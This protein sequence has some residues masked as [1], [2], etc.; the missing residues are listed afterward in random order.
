MLRLIVRSEIVGT[1][2]VVG[3]ENLVEAGLRRGPEGYWDTRECN[4]GRVGPASPPKGGS[5]S[6]WPVTQSWEVREWFSEAISGYVLTKGVRGVVGLS[7][8]WESHERDRS[9]SGTPGVLG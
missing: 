1:A 4:D 7:F 5:C 3:T 2:G 9:R 8:N 6:L